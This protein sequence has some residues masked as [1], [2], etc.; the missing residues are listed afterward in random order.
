M[1]LTAKMSIPDDWGS[2]AKCPICRSNMLR[3][4]HIHGTPDLMIC[5]QCNTNFLI[6]DGGSHIWIT[7]L[8]PMLQSHANL[9]ARWMTFDETHDYISKFIDRNQTSTESAASIKPTIQA[10][11][12]EVLKAKLSEVA[13]SWVEGRTALEAEIA[14]EITQ[15]VLDLYRLGNPPERIKNIL[16]RSDG[17]DA[18]LVESAISEVEAID[19][20]KRK[21]QTRWLWVAGIIT[22]VCLLI[23][24][25]TL[26]LWS[27]ISR[28]P[29]PLPYIPE[30]FISDTIYF[31]SSLL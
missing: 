11:N 25:G 2:R 6:E 16:K 22:M 24:I 1:N 12:P 10:P 17:L 4:L 13:P 19:N 9:K 20:Q 5:N 30:A 28:S 21:R 7:E 31:A 8:P 29:Y 27:F 23:S 3:V 26:L 18:E 15:K 14:P